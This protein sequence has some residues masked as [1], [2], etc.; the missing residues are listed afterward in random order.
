MSTSIDNRI[1]NMQFD[2]AKFEKNINT[3]QKSL[4]KLDQLLKFKNAGK[5]FNDID[6]AAGKVNFSAM[7][8]SLQTISSRF[9]NLGIVGVTVL[10]NLTNRAVD[11][12]FKIGNALTSAITTGGKNR[13][14]NIEAARFQIE[15]LE[16]DWEKVLEDVN[17]GVKDT[18]YGLDAA[19][20]VASQ[21]MA[22]QVSI[23]DNMKSSLRSISG[24]A[25]M[26]NSTYEDIGS[27]YTTV[28]GNGRLMSEQLLQ[29][30]SRG[31]NAAAALGQ[32]LGKSE[33]EI[34]DMVSKGE[35]D[36]QTFANAMDAAFGKHAKE[37]NK[38]FT[39][40]LAN[41][42]AA[43]SRIGAAFYQPGLDYARDVINALTPVID[44]AKKALTPFINLTERGMATLSKY[45]VSILNN[46]D[47]KATLGP[48]ID[49]FS[50]LLQGLVPGLRFL[51][52]T[53]TDVTST[54][55]QAFSAIFPPV[56]NIKG[57]INDLIKSFTDFARNTRPS[58]ETLNNLTRIFKGVFAA[59]NIVR[60]GATFLI[61]V[62]GSILVA[63]KPVGNQLLA[64]AAALGDFIVKIDESTKSGSGFASVFEKIKN[65]ISTL[66]GGLGSLLSSV[67]SKLNNL[68]SFTSNAIS[69][70]G[71][72]VGEAFTA[73]INKVKE[74]MS[75]LMSNF[76]FSDI[77]SMINA[78]LIGGVIAALLKGFGKIKAIMWKYT[79]TFFGNQ[80]G[81]F[82]IKIQNVLNNISGAF[83]EFGRNMKTVQLMNIAKSI[84]VLA[85]G[86]YILAQVDADK[87]AGSVAAM[88]VLIY[89][90]VTAMEVLADI[91]NAEKLGKISVLATSMIAVAIAIDFL[92]IAV[93]KLGRL[94]IKEL[95]KGLAGVQILLME[96]S[97]FLKKAEFDKIT[98]KQS[99]GLILIATSLNILASAVKKLGNINIKELIKG[100][101]SIGILLAEIAIF[102][103]MIGKPKGMIQAG[104]GIT[105]LA[106]GMLILSKAV[107]E[108]SSLSIEELVKGLGGIAAAMIAISIAMNFMP[109]NMI[110][111]GL[112]ILAV[113]TAIKILNGPLQDMGKMSL[114]E[115]AKS[116]GVLG[117]A[118]IILA[119]AMKLMQ[120]SIT[121]AIALGILTT[122]LV[123]FLPV[124]RALGTMSIEEIAKSLGVLAG[125]F[126]VLGVASAVLTP[127][128]PSLLA[129]SGAITL[130]GVGLAAIGAGVL[131]FAIGMSILAASGAAGIT[132]FTAIVM[133][134]IE[135]IPKAATALAE[136]IAAFIQAI[137]SN[138]P[139]IIEGI[140]TL[141]Q[142]ILT[143]LIEVIPQVLELA[144]TLIQGL[145]TTVTELIPSIVELGMTL[146]LSLLQ[147]IASNIYQIVVT[148]AQIVIEFLNGIAAQLPGIIQAGFDLMI[149]FLNGLADGIRNNM[150]L[151]LDAVWNVI[152]AIIES[153]LSTLM[154]AIGGM[155]SAGQEFI[156]GAIDGIGKGLE[157]AKNAV[158]DIIRGAIDKVTSFVGDM[159]NAGKD[160]IQG[161]IDGIKSMFESVGNVISDI[162]SNIIGGI[163]GILGIAS[164]SKVFRQIGIFTMEGL[165]LGIQKMSSAV[166]KATKNEGSNIV[167][168][169]NE[170]LS[171]VGRDIVN[172]LS[173]DLTIRPVLDL[174]DVNKGIDSIYSS[175]DRT[176][177]ISF[178]AT[179][180]KAISA[181]KLNTEPTV[182]N[183]D[184]TQG[185]TVINNFDMT[186]NNY[187]PKALSRIDIY[188]NTK[189]QF[190]R[191]KEAIA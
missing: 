11:A 14:L 79:T 66:A 68:F 64:I 131:A 177:S 183:N 130:L 18:A 40:A 166:T 99:I 88:S 86:L 142:S 187:S 65:V 39:G 100:L 102:T 57:R 112:G 26:T 174:T 7:E 71:P 56:D 189:N 176:A 29:L 120:G 17:Y 178:D 117:G 149:S 15:G 43:L 135:L 92:T 148:A 19:A 83:T 146:I 87:L 160:L 10:Q 13:A 105:A 69:Q 191:L 2:N 147:G 30:S 107:T 1:V 55:G 82:G 116:L 186:Q 42:K 180:N 169:M 81:N 122:A 118:L 173:D 80:V 78:G 170:T 154:G 22:S 119:G 50:T 97:A 35:I 140:V 60:R 20:K 59:M 6:K 44:D 32:Q 110:S 76:D 28:A 179:S 144:V 16:G 181:L 25:A 124:L 58:E 51:K 111:S 128:I 171:N 108:L 163:K 33:K 4:S 38:T 175:F 143:A 67:F 106:T 45:A 162:G 5:G 62:F 74:F 109:R 167:D 47:F 184:S 115:I 155:L 185:N 103:K 52:Y 98:I 72:K 37:A 157:G 137:V 96:L 125:M 114:K 46:F 156:G 141:V 12:A 63:L 133:G 113:A 164:P 75:G 31:L 91:T 132:A 150:G 73:I 121:G 159:L 190:S 90:L 145:I 54:I 165:I 188:R 27:I 127:L 36:F 53:F 151:V 41:M 104:I 77:A 34:R 152:S 172:D 61:S 23:G 123:L 126:V 153:V 48:S 168:T 138:A 182:G 94:N 9:S 21:L 101:G 136:G 134:I 139:T 129:L 8:K 93:A 85:A 161:L 24:V 3:T 70:I 95:I 89:E 158:S 49:A 84:L